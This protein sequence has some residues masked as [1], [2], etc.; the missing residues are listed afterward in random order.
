[1]NAIILMA[2]VALVEAA[3]EV[4]VEGKVVSNKTIDILAMNGVSESDLQRP[5]II[6][7]LPRSLTVLATQ[8]NW[9]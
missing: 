5:E 3:H 1:M 6:Q 2:I 7:D 9:C 4:T 8:G